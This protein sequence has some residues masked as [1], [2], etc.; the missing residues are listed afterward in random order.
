MKEK[1]RNYNQQNYKM[2][3]I[4]LRF[5]AQLKDLAGVGIDEIELTDKEQIHLLLER[6]VERYDSK[7]GDIL[8][9]KNGDYRHSNL[10]VIN[11]CQVNYDEDSVLN[12]GDQVTLMSPISGG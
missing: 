11:Q 3:K 2:R 1:L 6:L 9:D 7:F 8:F 5:T 4:K 10:I 12:D